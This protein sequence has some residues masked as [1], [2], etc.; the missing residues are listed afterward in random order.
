MSWISDLHLLECKI[1]AGNI[2]QKP[3]FYKIKKGKENTLERNKLNKEVN[4][5]IVNFKKWRNI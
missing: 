4:A 5:A 3:D 1:D 2:T